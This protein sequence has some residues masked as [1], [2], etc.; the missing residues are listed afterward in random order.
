MVINDVKT[1]EQVLRVDAESCDMWRTD[2]AGL[3]PKWGIYRYIGDNRSMENL[4][5]DEE[6]RYADFSIQ[7]IL[8][9]NHI[10][11]PIVKRES[12]HKTYDVLG[13][14]TAQVNRQGLIII[15]GGKY[16]SKK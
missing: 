11:Q 1:G 5:R 9:P 15:K 2:C 14:R 13:R 10:C 7:K 6:L 3:R 8:Q 16:F 4:L 12:E